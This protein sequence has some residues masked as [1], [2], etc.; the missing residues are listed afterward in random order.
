MLGRWLPEEVVRERERRAESAPEYPTTDFL[1]PRSTSVG[2]ALIGYV[3]QITA[4]ASLM[5]I[6]RPPED[7]LKPR[8]SRRLTKVPLGGSFDFDLG[9]SA[10]RIL[11]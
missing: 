5:G 3:K 9:S 10:L 1:A 4:C 8:S 11:E 2:Q 6:K 7:R